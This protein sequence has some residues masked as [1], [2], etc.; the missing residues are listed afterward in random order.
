VGFARR[1]GAVVVADIDGEQATRVVESILAA[2]GRAVPFVADVS[3]PEQIH[4]MVSASLE[5]FGRLDFLHNNAFGLPSDLAAKRV[6]LLA[7]VDQAVWD[8]TLQVGLT[9]VMQTTKRVLPIMQRQG[10]GTIVNTASI[11]ALYADH[12]SV[13]YNT[14][15]AGL[16][17]LTR[18]TAVEYGHAG[19]RANCICP[20]PIDTPLLRRGMAARK[21]DNG[22][23]IIQ[24]FV[25]LGR[26]GRSDE[27]AEVVLFLASDLASFVTGAVIP[28]DG[29][30]SAGAGFAALTSN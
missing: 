25:P 12:G 2:G 8:R 28:V 1:G 29:G 9:A 15:K 18:V 19:I 30:V 11:A 3:Q 26:I 14:A 16:V 20:G 7:E 13:S 4:A 23:A 6:A 24:S 17:H 27:V 5:A 22:K 10:G 21:I